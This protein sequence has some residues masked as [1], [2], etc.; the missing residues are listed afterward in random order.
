MGYVAGQDS[1]HDYP[2]QIRPLAAS[3]DNEPGLVI[4]SGG[5]NDV[6]HKEAIPDIVSG[7]DHTLATIRLVW[8]DARIVVLSPVGSAAPP[9]PELSKL[10]QALQPVITRHG[11]TYLDLKMPLSGH[12]EWISPDGLHPNDAGYARLAQVTA[13]ALKNAHL[14]QK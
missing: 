9:P 11:A 7:A 5:W 10:G 3:H 14:A 13:T 4:V 6:A 1:G 12:P 2:N 8:P